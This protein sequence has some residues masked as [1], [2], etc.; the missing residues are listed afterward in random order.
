MAH[1]ATIGAHAVNGVSKL[2]SD[3]IRRDLFP[4]FASLW[5]ARFSNKTNGVTQRVWILQANPR[6]AS[7]LTSSSG[8]DGSPISPI[9]AACESSRTMPGSTRSSPP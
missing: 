8:P 7:V 5:P 1:L 2:H 3:L 9:S 6:L 4:E